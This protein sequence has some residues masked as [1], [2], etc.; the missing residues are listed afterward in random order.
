M[1]RI[2]TAIALAVAIA[3]CGSVRTSPQSG[4]EDPV[5]GGAAGF[6]TYQP[7]DTL[8][9][10]LRGKGA[11]AVPVGEDVI[12]MLP[13][14]SAPRIVMEPEAGFATGLQSRGKAEGAELIGRALVYAGRSSDAQVE[15]IQDCL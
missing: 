9:E 2:V 5:R 1:T 4:G 3:G 7:R 11:A 12:Q 15:L 6:K 13:A 14:S 8:L 10:C